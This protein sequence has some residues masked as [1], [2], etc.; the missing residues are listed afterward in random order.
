[1]SA[2]AENI[3]ADIGEAFPHFDEAFALRIAAIAVLSYQKHAGPGAVAA[4]TRRQ[5]DLLQF[6]R[7]YRLQNKISPNYV[8]M[9]AGINQKSKS[10]INRLVNGLEERGALSRS[11]GG[12]RNLYLTPLGE[13]VAA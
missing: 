13:K 3:A 1:M 2:L 12:A 10:G 6:I 7:D 11:P 9:A 5:L 4:V 8:E